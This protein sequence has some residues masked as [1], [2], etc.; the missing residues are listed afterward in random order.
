MKVNVMVMLSFLLFLVT[1]FLSAGDVR[2]VYIAKLSYKDHHNSRG[3]RLQ[4][5]AGILRQDRANYHKFYRRDN[6]DTYDQFFASKRNRAVFE[7]MLNNSYM[8]RDDRN[9]ILYREPMVRV[10]IYYGNSISVSIF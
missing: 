4:T 9:T 7:R 2:E 8:S 1:T 3:D 5:V 10:T 6:A